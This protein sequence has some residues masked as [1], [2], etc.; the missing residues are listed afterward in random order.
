MDGPFVS[1]S[2][3]RN[4]NPIS[5]AAVLVKLSSD[6]IIL[7]VLHSNCGCPGSGSCPRARMAEHRLKD[8]VPGQPRKSRHIDGES[9][10][11]G[12]RIHQMR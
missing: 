2:P 4:C 8:R 3:T 9:E 12:D 11:E 1:I 5:F 7:R 10:M 6:A